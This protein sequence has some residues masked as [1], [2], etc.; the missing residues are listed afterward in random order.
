MHLLHHLKEGEWTQITE[1]S[2]QIEGLQQLV[3]DGDGTAWLFWNGTIYKM[4]EDLPEPVASLIA[5]R[6]VLDADGQ[7]WFIAWYEGQDWLWTLETE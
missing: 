3:L 5:R 2:Y 1:S 4:I 6:I 7:P